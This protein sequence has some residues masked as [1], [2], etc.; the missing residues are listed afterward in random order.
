MSSPTDQSTA[1]LPVSL[2]GMDERQQQALEFMFEKQAG[3]AYRIVSDE[4]A[5]A[6]IVDLDHY[7]CQAML[8]ARREAHGPRPCLYLSV[9]DNPLP[10]E[11][12]GIF[13]RKPVH[14]DDFLQTMKMLDRRARLNGNG[15]SPAAKQ[16][17]SGPIT[18]S[19]LTQQSLAAGKH[20]MSAVQV[21]ANNQPS[22]FVGTA[23]DVDLDDLGQLPSIY[24]DP[25]T[26]LQGRVVRAWGRVADKGGRFAMPGPGPTLY[27]YPD[28]GMVGLD[29]DPSRL[30]PYACMP[31][32]DG[33][34]GLRRLSEDAPVALE[35]LAYEALLWKLALWASRGRLPADTPLDVP[36]F[37]RYWPNFPRLDITPWALAITALWARRPH[38]LRDTVRILGIPQRYV[39][40][41]YSAAH[42]LD[43]VAPSRRSVDSLFAAEP[44]QQ[45]PQR[46][47]F[48]RLLDHLRI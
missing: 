29:S 6:W 16:S 21:L 18:L 10:M 35:H 19:P 22:A 34:F 40:A 42:A 33:D 27:L 15:N 20:A 4:S 26:Y 14:M 37:V 28:L 48:S 13:L 17:E 36:I 46:G 8:S 32:L 45:P 7:Q 47:L 24:Y 12:D 11:L 1:I 23:P 38:S 25:E 43:L 5:M 3:R 31:N 2:V 30:R 41:Y 44:L 39:F 9:R